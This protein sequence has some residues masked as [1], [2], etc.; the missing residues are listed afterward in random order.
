MAVPTAYSEAQLA[1]FMHSV[2]GKTASIIGWSSPDSYTEAVYDAA[3]MAGVD[4]VADTT[5]VAK[6]RACARLAVWQAVEA[7]TVGY[8]DF[9]EDQQSFRMHQVHIQAVAKVKE[10]R[11]EASR[12]GINAVAMTSTTIRRISPYDMVEDSERSI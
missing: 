3:I 4:D 2:L 7:D 5:D 6:L 11:R 10:A 8:H 1:D 12:H 9:S